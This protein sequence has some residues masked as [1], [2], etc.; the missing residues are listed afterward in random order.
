MK[1]L[2]ELSELEISKNLHNLVKDR[3]YAESKADVLPNKSIISAIFD[4]LKK[5][6]Y[7]PNQIILDVQGI[8]VFLK[9]HPN[10]TNTIMHLF[11]LYSE[12]HLT[13]NKEFNQ[14]KYQLFFSRLYEEMKKHNSDV[15]ESLYFNIAEDK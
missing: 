6:G 8:G 2:S 12:K 10:D 7:Y 5:V 3:L 14:L 15:A 11:D 4:G 9:T 13:S 1:K